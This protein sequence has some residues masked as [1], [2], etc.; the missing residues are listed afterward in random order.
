MRYGGLWRKGC[1]APPGPARAPPDA[2]NSGPLGEEAFSAAP[3]LDND[4]S[5]VGTAEADLRL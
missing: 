1:F 2:A 3:V 4:M 5:D